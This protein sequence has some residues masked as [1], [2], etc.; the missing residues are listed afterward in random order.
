M[1]KI[2]QKFE[3]KLEKNIGARTLPAR[4]VQESLHP[5]HRRGFAPVFDSPSRKTTFSAYLSRN[6]TEF[7][8]L[9]AR[10]HRSR[11]AVHDRLCHSDFLNCHLNGFGDYLASIFR[12][13]QSRLACNQG[14]TVTSSKSVNK[15]KEHRNS[16]KQSL[17]GTC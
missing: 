11:R 16:R 4:T 9:N 7:Q 6:V 1:P 17:V 15:E 13:T 8:I 2:S 5:L 12:Q 14:A 3:Y 10:T